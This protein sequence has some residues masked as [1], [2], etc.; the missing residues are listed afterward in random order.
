[1][2]KIIFDVPEESI[3]RLLL[4]NIF[5]YDLFSVLSNI[6]FTNYANDTTPYVIGN[7]LKEVMDSLKNALDDF[8]C[9]F[10]SNQMKSNPNSAI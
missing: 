7:G 5:I 8:F 1:M 3:I 4:L 9:W 10:T 6:D 2:K